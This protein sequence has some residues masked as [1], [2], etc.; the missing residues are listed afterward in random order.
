MV[1][2]LHA[3]ALVVLFF[4][5]GKCN[6]RLGQSALID[7]HFGNDYRQPGFIHLS[8]PPA[9]LLTRQQKLSL[10][11]GIMVV[12]IAPVILRDV[13]SRDEELTIAEGAEGVSQRCLACTNRLDLGSAQLDAGDKL[14]DEFIIVGGPPVFDDDIACI[15]LHWRRQANMEKYAA[16]ASFDSRRCRRRNTMTVTNT[17]A[18]ING[19]FL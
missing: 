9:Q 2:L 17:V 3:L 13:H 6:L 12:E 8:F 14:L 1:A 7:E 11:E 19:T 4:A 5:P 16:S 18:I 10:T 15:A